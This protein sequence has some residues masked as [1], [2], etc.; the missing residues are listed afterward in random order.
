VPEALR[1]RWLTSKSDVVIAIGAPIIG[2]I[3]LLV[4]LATGDVTTAI[5]GG[6]AVVLGLV[7]AVPLARGGEDEPE[8]G[9]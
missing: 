7:Y 1:K 8:D 4:G 2:V 6:V 9:A 3:G 5:F